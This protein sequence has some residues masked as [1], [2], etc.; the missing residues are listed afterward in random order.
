MHTID[1]ERDAAD[2]IARLNNLPRYFDGVI[3]QISIRADKG[4]YLVDWMVP[5]IVES[6]GNVLAGAPFDATETP[7]VIWQDFNDKLARLDLE[8]AIADGLREGARKALLASVKPAYERLIAA[9]E[10]QQG[11]AGPEDGVW[12]IPE[13][14]RLLR[15][16]L[17]CFYNDRPEPRGHPRSRP[18]QC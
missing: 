5:K 8:P 16:S 13:R 3:E 18:C 9:V 11:M 15:Q 1:S 17:A 7:S 2:Y 6:A 10:A 12:P 4:M 14:R